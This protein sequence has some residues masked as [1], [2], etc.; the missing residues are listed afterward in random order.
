[1]RG[2]GGHLPRRP[3]ADE[4][5]APRERGGRCSGLLRQGRSVRLPPAVRGD[6]Y[7]RLR[8]RGDY[9][10]AGEGQIRSSNGWMLA[11]LVRE[12]GGLPRLAKPV[13]DGID[14]LAAAVTSEETEPIC[15][16]PREAYPSGITT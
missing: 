1:M 12:A 14:E 5:H 11:A 6:L 4:R 16:L 2:G 13:P 8:A 15:S 3:G 9:R 7:R 10:A